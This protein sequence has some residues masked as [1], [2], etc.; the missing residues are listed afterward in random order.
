MNR[1]LGTGDH[2]GD[3]ARVVFIISAPCLR[4][5]VMI[6][7]AG[8]VEVRSLYVVVVGVARGQFGL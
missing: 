3:R 4:F 8:G 2:G 1:D 7:G 6:R 5:S